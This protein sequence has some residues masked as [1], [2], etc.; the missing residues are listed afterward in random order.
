MEI[1][2][3]NGGA[4]IDPILEQAISQIVRRE[5]VAALTAQGAPRPRGFLDT[6]ETMALLK[7]SRTKLYELIAEGKLVPHKLGSKN[8]FRREDVERLL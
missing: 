3:R 7:C 4:G 2:D 1:D 6:P 5:V 8:R